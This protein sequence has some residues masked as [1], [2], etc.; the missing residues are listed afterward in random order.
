MAASAYTT[1]D[2]FGPFPNATFGGSGIPNDS[3]AAAKQI[4]QGTDTI[5]IALNATQ[6]F[7]NPPLT[8]NGAGIFYATK[9]SNCGV[10]TDPVGCPS[11]NQGALWNFNYY[12][13]VAGGGNIEDYQIDI[14]YDFDPAAGTPLGSLGRIDVTA[15]LILNS[16]TATRVEDSQNLL[17]GFLASGV[18]GYVF[19]PGGAFNPNVNG[20]YQFL[21]TVS[22]PNFG[23][24]LDT[25][26]IEVQVVPVPAAA[27]LFGSALGLLAWVRRRTT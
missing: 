7:S 10:D 15:A 1:Y 12:I 14:Y 6:R 19:Q 21:I 9:G 26:A 20:N 5:T 13:D 25:V 23:V 18:A 11:L 3:V 17:F 8:D 16:A 4:V 27:W 2:T 22:D 24:P